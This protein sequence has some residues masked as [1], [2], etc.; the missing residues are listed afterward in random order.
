[1]S[2]SPLTS[3]ASGAP[4]P[5]L[6]AGSFGM[7][8]DVADVPLY[9]RTELV[10]SVVHFGVGA[11]HRAHQAVYFD[12]LAR[13]GI[14]SEWG[15]VGVGLHR[16]EL[17]QVLAD[18]DN[19]YTVV[20]RG[21]ERDELRVIGVLTRYLFAPDDPE[22]VLE[23]LADERTRLVTLTITG[24]GY[25]AGGEVDVTDPD[26]VRDVEHP[27]AP[28][29]V[30][31]YLVEALDRRRA[32]G[33]G[34]FTVLS[35]DNTAHNGPTTRAAVVSTARLRDPALAR[36]I[37]EHVT[38]PSSMVDRITPVTTPQV[39]EGV[40]SR[41]GLGDRWPV[42][43]EP[44]SQWVVEDSF[45]NG[46]PPLEEVGV[47]FVR[48][49][50]PYETMKTRLL[51]GAHCAL[52]FLGTL[53]GYRTSHEAMADPVVRG[54]VAGYLRETSVLLLQVPGIDLEEYCATL[55]ERFA[56]PQVGDQ[57][58]RLCR[59]GS[60]K[61]PAYVLPSLQITLR[62]YLPR[63]HLVLTVAAL[64]RCLQGRDHAGEAITLEDPR[65]DRLQQAAREG[66][67]DPRP[68][69]AQHDVFG[70]LGSDVHLQAELEAALVALEDGPLEA[71]ARLAAPRGAA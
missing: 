44:F 34:P 36:W 47:Q 33:T 66:G 14:S 48:N 61:V 18:Q 16:P 49:V 71:A 1:M 12:Q 29:T 63:E 4:A 65:A 24:S 27:E 62:Q 43:T 58:A 60:T 21:A 25:P 56:N 26:V 69:M 7:L 37:E 23:V 31:G 42:V 54:F 6:N 64:M 38:F 67:T 40:D 22:A 52:G 30:F 19:L 28:G 53:A 46:R 45:C 11:F 59:R 10:P 57:L 8:A 9:D 3:T 2:T 32:A 68:L 35:C 39:Q 15:V 5:A 17:S 51:N 41:Y 55:L 20:V 13:E 70:L 50:T